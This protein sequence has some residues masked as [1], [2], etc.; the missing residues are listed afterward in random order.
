MAENRPFLDFKAIK[1]RVTIA[2]VL[3]RYQ[4]SLVRVNQTSL[5]GNC[6]LPTHSSGSKSTFF[7]NEAKSV[8]Y[9]HSDSCKKNGQ[10]AGGNV[11]DFVAVM[12]RCSAYDAAKRLDELFPATSDHGAKGASEPNAAAVSGGC[13]SEEANPPPAT[14]NN[15]PLPFVLK[16]VNPEHPMIQGRGI[17][18]ETAKLYGVGYFPGK[19]SMAS[20]IVFPLQE[21]LRING[22]GTAQVMLVGYAGRTTLDVTPEN[23]KWKLPAGLRKSFLYGMERCDP[24]KPL[25]LCESLWGPLWFREHGLQAASLMGTEMTKEQE[26]CLD[27]YPTITV[28]FDNDAA[29]IEKAALISE[30]LKAKHRVLKARLIE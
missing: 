17:T 8:W 12:E 23:P 3:A 30:R 22:D 7:V 26:R 2:D 20:R 25:I 14:G 21:L 1:A 16:D 29:G 6:P 13:R 19:G 18:I 15:R 9:C 11:I 10:R 5:K 28:A 4:V 24:A 27:P